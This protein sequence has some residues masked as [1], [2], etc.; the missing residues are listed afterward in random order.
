MKTSPFDKN[1]VLAVMCFL[2]GV[3]G[4]IMAM[5]SLCLWYKFGSQLFTFIALAYGGLMVFT[6]LYMWRN[7]RHFTEKAPVMGYWFASSVLLFSTLLNLLTT[8]SITSLPLFHPKTF[9]CLVMGLAAMVLAAKALKKKPVTSNT[10][11]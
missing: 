9:S 3:I 5:I 1:R 7:R 4:M 6:A 8:P 2:T 10:S 11:L